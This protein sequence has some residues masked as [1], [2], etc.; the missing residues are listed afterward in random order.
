MT[1]NLKYKIKPK[2]THLDFTTEK[3]IEISL[4]A[5]EWSREYSEEE[6]SDDLFRME[7]KG[8]LLIKRINNPVINLPIKKQ[9][10][11]KT[12]S[13]SEKK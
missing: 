3:G 2:K 1:Q 12:S 4:K 11:N 6:M 10:V 9:V 5:R 8:L 13:T 7:E